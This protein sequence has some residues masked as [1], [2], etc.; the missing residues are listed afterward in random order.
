MKNSSTQELEN[1]ARLRQGYGGPAEAMEI[2]WRNAKAG[3]G[4]VDGCRRRLQDF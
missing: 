2:K 4:Q 3:M 1:S